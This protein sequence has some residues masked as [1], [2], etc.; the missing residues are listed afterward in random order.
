[1]YAYRAFLDLYASV[2]VLRLVGVLADR[3]TAI[4][5]FATTFGIPSLQSFVLT[6]PLGLMTLASLHVQTPAQVASLA[7]IVSYASSTFMTAF[8][9]SVQETVPFYYD[10]ARNAFSRMFSTSMFLNS[11]V[12]TLLLAYDPAVLYLMNGGTTGIDPRGKLSP[13]AQALDT[14]ARIMN[15]ANALEGQDFILR[16]WITEYTNLTVD[17]VKETY[18][19]LD[20]PT[21]Q[22]L[23]AINE[24]SALAAR[25]GIVDVPQTVFTSLLNNPQEVLRLAQLYTRYKQAVANGPQDRI[26]PRLLPLPAE[27]ILPYLLDTSSDTSTVIAP[28]HLFDTNPLDNF[29]PFDVSCQSE[30]C[31]RDLMNLHLDTRIVKG[32]VTTEAGRV[33]ALFLRNAPLSDQAVAAANAIVSG[34]QDTSLLQLSHSIIFLVLM[35][36]LLI[37]GARSISPTLALPTAL[38]FLTGGFVTRQLYLLQGTTPPLLSYT[39]VPPNTSAIVPFTPPEQNQLLDLVLDVLKMLSYLKPI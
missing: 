30:E 13:L 16:E 10:A 33:Q 1:M 9:P 17:Y 7:F 3:F 39:V 14:S 35:V 29:N 20:P 25:E 31:L 15:V 26:K 24:I 12:F 27:P 34:V 8:P 5:S 21:Q 36:I 23:D 32:M 38:Y 6:P 11:A 28:L 19:A 22:Q 2:R 4:A 18:P 37:K